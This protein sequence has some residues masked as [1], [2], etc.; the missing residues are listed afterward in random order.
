MSHLITAHVLD[1]RIKAGYRRV[2]IAHLQYRI[3]SGTPEIYAL[4]GAEK[5]NAGASGA[6]AGRHVSRA[7]FEAG[8]DLFCQRHVEGQ[9]VLQELLF[10]SKVLAEWPFR[11]RSV[12]VHFS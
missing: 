11:A 3:G 2:P 8:L 6:A 9:E 10:F 7:K 4:L 5:L 12:Y 1:K